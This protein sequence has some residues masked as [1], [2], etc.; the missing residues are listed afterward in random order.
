MERKGQAAMEYLM[1]YGWA[2]L[3]IVIVIS[4]LLLLN[5]GPSAQCN[6]DDAAIRCDQTLPVIAKDLGGNQLMYV[7]INNGKSN[8]INVTGIQCS[9][10]SAAAVA[11][12][13]Q[14][15]PGVFIPAGSKSAIN[16]TCADAAGVQQ[17]NSFSGKLYVQYKGENDPAG[18]PAHTTSGGIVAKYS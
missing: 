6:L 15:N 8:A 11:T 1:T 16:F 10:D 5:I 13:V 12:Y 18:F 17:G 4:V 2:L 14:L 3:V 7:V 9:K